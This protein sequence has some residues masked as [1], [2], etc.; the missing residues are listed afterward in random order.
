[1]PAQDFAIVVRNMAGYVFD[2]VFVETHHSDQTIT[3]SPVETG[4]SISDHKFMQPRRLT[5]RA[6]VSD[7]PIHASWYDADWKLSP[8]D[9]DAFSQG[10]FGGQNVRR[11]VTAWQI[12]L[13]LQSMDGVFDVQTGLE[14]YHNMQIEHL[15]TE[16]DAKKAGAL[17]FTADLREVQV[18]STN[19]VLV[20][21]RPPKQ[22]RQMS[23]TITRGEEGHQAEAPVKVDQKTYLL[24]LQQKAAQ[25]LG[26]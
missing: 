21:P 2:S 12:M 14:L 23:P 13:A 3:D 11:S 5:I 8:P 4:V 10:A 15:E 26:M 6:G 9:S 20:P 18:V 7:T 25:L 17:F 16:Q 1:M 24:Q 22:A 19:T